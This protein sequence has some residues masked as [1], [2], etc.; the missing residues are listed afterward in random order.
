M[1]A[2]ACDVLRER[3]KFG[4][5]MAANSP[6]MATTII[7]STKVNPEL[8]CFVTFIL[9]GTSFRSGVNEAQGGYV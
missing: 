9:H 2:F 3:T 4:R 8:P 7:I 1:Q 5:A 6:M